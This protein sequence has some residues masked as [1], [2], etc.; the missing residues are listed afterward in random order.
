MPLTM[1]VTTTMMVVMVVVVLILWSTGGRRGV[2]ALALH[3]EKHLPGK[4][5]RTTIPL[6]GHRASAPDKEAAAAAVEGE[7][8]RGEPEEEDDD[9]SGAA[10]SSHG[11]RAQAWGVMGRARSR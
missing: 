6:D 3:G 11:L 10:G 1:V 9:G 7:G 2:E 8:E 5:G 4:R